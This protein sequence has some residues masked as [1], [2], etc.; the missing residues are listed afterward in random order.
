MEG[1]FRYPKTPSDFDIAISVLCLKHFLDT[2]LFVH[3]FWRICTLVSSLCCLV[4]ILCSFP[5]CFLPSH[6]TDFRRS[7]YIILS[8]PVINNVSLVLR[9]WLPIMKTYRVCNSHVTLKFEEMH[10]Y[11]WTLSVFVYLLISFSVCIS[12]GLF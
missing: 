5:W 1:I 3:L 8:V 12:S 4:L 7:P 11:L 10:T 2:Y 6:V 9:L